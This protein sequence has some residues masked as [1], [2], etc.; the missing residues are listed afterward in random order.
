M[1]GKS[2]GNVREGGAR[3]AF[4][5][6]ELCSHSLQ[7]SL[8][9][10]LADPSSKVAAATLNCLNLSLAATAA[11]AAAGAPAGRAGGSAAATGA[12][13]PL[14]QLASDE[15]QPH[16]LAA[17]VA[18][19]DHSLPLIRAKAAVGLVLLCRW[20]G[21]GLV[22]GA[23]AGDI[24]QVQC[25]QSPAVQPMATSVARAFNHMPCCHG[26]CAHLPRRL[27][28]RLLLEGCKLKLMPLAERLAREQDSHTQD[29]VLALHAHAAAH[30]AA[31]CR[32]IDQHLSAL[33]AAAGGGSNR[34]L[35]SPPG[36]AAT[37]GPPVALAQFAVLLHL[38]TSPSFRP[39]VATPELTQQLASF[40]TAS[41][42]PAVAAAPGVGDF[43]VSL[44]HVLEALCQVGGCGLVT[45]AWAA[46]LRSPGDQGLSWLRSPPVPPTCPEPLMCT[47][48]R[49]DLLCPA[50]V[51]LRTPQQSEL[52]LAQQPSMMGVLLPALCAA[53][54]RPHESGDVRFFCLRMLSDVLGLYLSEQQPGG[55]SAQHAQR[56]SS[57]G[58][59]GAVLP[60]ALRALLT[61][62]VLPAVPALLDQEDPM[63]LYALKVAGLLRLWVG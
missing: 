63:P 11:A 47:C 53:V 46:G 22:L 3:S 7:T 41:A 6:H 28:P 59:D 36:A 50:P 31:T 54:G 33:L 40:L 45:G 32:A 52:V 62:S 55:S 49:A 9:A 24:T 21:G 42:H 1:G 29:A 17:L 30:V 37:A 51:F 13:A 39:A 10:G 27:Q 2:S 38:V 5:S 15:E 60:P 56:R 43:R 57:S 20:A 35:G 12:S 23:G 26:C 25:K 58:G 61:S 44:L 14:Q 8:S 4:H 16:V 48:S 18:A 19:L 34:R